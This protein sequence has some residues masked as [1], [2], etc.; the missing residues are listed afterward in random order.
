MMA[1]LRSGRLR[2]SAIFGKILKNIKF[3]LTNKNNSYLF[4]IIKKYKKLINYQK[5]IIFA[6]D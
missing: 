5:Q 6:G 1:L 2:E 3:F 4:N